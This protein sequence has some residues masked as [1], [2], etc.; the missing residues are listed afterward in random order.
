MVASEDVGLHATNEIPDGDLPQK[1]MKPLEPTPGSDCCAPHRVVDRMSELRRCQPAEASVRAVIVVVTAPLE[2]ADR[3]WFRD[4][5]RVSFKN[6]ST[7]RPLK[8]SREVFGSACQGR[9][10]ARPPWP[11]RPLQDRVAGELASVVADDHLALPRLDDPV[12]LT[13]KTQTGDRAIGRYV[14]QLFSLAQGTLP[15]IR[16]VRPATHSSRGRRAA[17]VVASG[18]AGL[19]KK[20]SVVTLRGRS[21]LR[22]ESDIDTEA[23]ARVLDVLERR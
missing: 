4:E 9:C 6:S 8:L 12:E 19:P 17:T 16:A 21:R 22:V 11:C 5:K 13:G 15:D 23:L 20:A 7:S 1:Q 18:A 3:A 2:S 10:S 14:R